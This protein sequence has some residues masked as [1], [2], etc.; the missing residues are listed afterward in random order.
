MEK[1]LLSLSTVRQYPSVII[2]E[3]K[4]TMTPPDARRFHRGTNGAAPKSA[5]ITRLGHQLKRP[6]GCRASWRPMGG[7]CPA[8]PTPSTRICASIVSNGSPMG[9]G[10]MPV[11]GDRNQ[12]PTVKFCPW[13]EFAS[14]VANALR[15]HQSLGKNDPWVAFDSTG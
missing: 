1:P 4:Y 13:A 6:F 11:H 3:K 15:T 14:L 7:I 2:D 8:G 12:P 10:V 9:S 5:L